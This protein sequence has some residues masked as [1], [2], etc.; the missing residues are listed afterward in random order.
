MPPSAVWFDLDESGM[1]AKMRSPKGYK[2]VLSGTVDQLEPE[3]TGDPAMLANVAL[4]HNLWA[5][6]GYEHQAV[7]QVGDAERAPLRKKADSHAEVAV[8]L[9]GLID[10]LVDSEREG[11]CSNC[12]EFSAHRKATSVN[13]RTSTYLCAACGSATDVCAA[14]GC[15]N[16]AARGLGSVQI[17]RF[18]A[19]HSH[20]IPSFER[21]RDRIEDLLGYEEFLNYDKPN[22]ARGVQLAMGSVLVSTAGEY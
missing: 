16:M 2:L 19:E 20:A 17:P 7:L 4:R 10:G 6:A 3:A 9:A 8:Q 14:P 22:L 21:A 18:C 15:T 5:Y 13:L 12:F 1:T 11:W